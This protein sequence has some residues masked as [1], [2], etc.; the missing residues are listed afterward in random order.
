MDMEFVEFDTWE[1]HNFR[2]TYSVNVSS[3]VIVY[4]WSPCV[5]IGGAA[6]LK[7]GFVNVG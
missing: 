1:K 3:F 4:M 2:C 6:V 5:T 7:S